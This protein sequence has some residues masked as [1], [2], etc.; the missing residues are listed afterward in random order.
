MSTKT[1]V[2]IFIVFILVW[3]VG[4]IALFNPSCSLP[5]SPEPSN[6]RSLTYEITGT[7]SKVF[8]TMYTSSGS[9]EQYND[10]YLPRTYSFSNYDYWYASISAQNLG[11]EGSVT[12]KIIVNGVV[13]Q[14]ATSSGG[15]TIAMTNYSFY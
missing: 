6:T 9:I 13:V 7:A 3:T 4:G 12:V 15:Y 1:G 11:P 2:I 8:V 10:V 5:V 14:Q